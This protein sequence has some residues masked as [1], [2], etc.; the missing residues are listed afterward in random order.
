MQWGVIGSN[1]VT[2]VLDLT[3]GQTTTGTRAIAPYEFTSSGTSNNID[4]VGSFAADYDSS[5]TAVS[6]ATGPL[7]QALSA[8]IELSNGGESWTSNDPSTGAFGTGY[9]IEQPT[10]G[11]TG[12]TNSVLDLYQLNPATQAFHTRGSYLG[13]FTLNASGDLI[14][15]PAAVPEPSTLGLT[16]LGGA[17]LLILARRRMNTSAV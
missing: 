9:N 13:D 7:G 12:P 11:L 4:N 6:G 8:T 17:M 15:S 10:T 5:E 1:S 16:A 14:F 3:A 2:N